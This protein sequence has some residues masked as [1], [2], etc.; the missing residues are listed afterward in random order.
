MMTAL[1]TLLANYHNFKFIFFFLSLL[2]IIIFT[3]IVYIV[4]YTYNIF[5]VHYTTIYLLYLIIKFFQ[6]VNEI[7]KLC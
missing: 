4:H 3:Y 5:I 6:K 2:S 1:Q 7:I